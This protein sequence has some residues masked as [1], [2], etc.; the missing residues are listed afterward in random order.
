[1][2]HLRLHFVDNCR[3]L[4]QIQVQLLTQ[5]SHAQVQMAACAEALAS[6][7]AVNASLAKVLETQVLPTALPLWSSKQRAP[8]APH[9]HLGSKANNARHTCYMQ[10][11]STNSPVQH[12]AGPSTPPADPQQAPSLEFS[13][14]SRLMPVQ[15]EEYGRMLKAGGAEVDALLRALAQQREEAQAV[16]AE[17]LLRLDQ[18]FKQVWGVKLGCVSCLASGDRTSR[19]ES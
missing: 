19:G 5:V 2:T 13:T 1:M 16:C 17:Q 9:A 7:D 12:I 11:P 3:Y 6:Q 18:S 10:L 4:A 14:S 8:L 15:D